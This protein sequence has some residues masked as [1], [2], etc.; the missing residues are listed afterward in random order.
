MK[1]V[2]M[3]RKM[4]MAIMAIMVLV[5]AFPKNN[6]GV[7]IF[8]LPFLICAIAIFLENI[9]L[10]FN[11]QKIANIFMYIFRIVF[12]IYVYGFL[13]YSSYY[14]VVNK[15]YALFIPISIFLLFSIPFLRGAFFGKNRSSRNKKS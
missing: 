9:F 10:F 14:A 12:F 8:I 5:W 6:L 3:F 1:R 13:G 4:V 15:N 11:N 2:I 7:K